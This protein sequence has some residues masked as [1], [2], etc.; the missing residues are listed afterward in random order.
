MSQANTWAEENIMRQ[1]VDQLLKPICKDEMLLVLDEHRAQ[2]TEDFK[3]KLKEL[4][5]TPVFVLGGCTSLVQP[6]DVVFNAP[7]KAA[8]EKIA[9]MHMLGSKAHVR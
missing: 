6:I 3:Q 8:V 5:T 9:Q 2:M 1:Y 7:F 4:S